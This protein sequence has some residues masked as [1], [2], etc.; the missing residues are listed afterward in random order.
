MAKTIRKEK[1]KRTVFALMFRYQYR[2]MNGTVFTPW[3]KHKEFF[4]MED[5]SRE[6]SVLKVMATPIDRTTKLKHEFDIVK[7]HNDKGGV[8]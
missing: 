7:A 3:I 2:T 4:T 1:A 5:A 6:K 8:E